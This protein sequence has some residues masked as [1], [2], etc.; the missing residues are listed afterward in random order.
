MKPHNQ[1]APGLDKKTAGTIQKIL[2]A[3]ARNT[4]DKR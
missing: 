2:N 4:S 1:H 3:W